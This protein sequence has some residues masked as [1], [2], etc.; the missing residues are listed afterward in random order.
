MDKVL[1]VVLREA[2]KTEG[3]PNILKELEEVVLEAAADAQQRG[4]P[5]AA[6]YREVANALADLFDK[7]M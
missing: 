6:T 5:S 7:T 2:V 3:L 4:V 1:A